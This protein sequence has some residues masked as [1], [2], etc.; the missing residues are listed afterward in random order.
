[1]AVTFFSQGGAEEVTGSRHFIQCEKTSVMLDCG[2]VQGHRGE[3]DRRNREWGGSFTPPDAVVLSHAHFDHCGLLPLL[4]QK[5][6][7]GNVYCT[8]PTAA[9]SNIVLLDSAKIQR[10]DHEFLQKEAHKNHTVF[11]GRPLYNENDIDK[12]TGHFV[13]IP[14]ETETNITPDSSVKFYNNAH[15]LGS[16]STLITIKEGLKK[17]RIFYTGDI[18]RAAHPFLPPSSYPPEAD[19]IIMEG[20]YGNRQHE[21]AEKSTQRLAEVIKE[22]A[23]GGGKTVIPA[24]AIDRTQHI[25]YTLHKLFT[26]GSIPDMPVFIDSP[27]AI[28]ATA[29]YNTYRLSYNDSYSV[30]KKRSEPFL[31]F[32]NLHYC[33]TTEESKK[34]NDYAGPCII[35]SASG[36]CE[37]GRILHHL[38]NT[39]ADSRNTILIIG[40]MAEDTLGR[41]IYNKA[42]VIKVFNRMLP[43]KARVEVFS[44]FSA[45]A[46]R[47]ELYRYIARLP[48]NKVKK[49][50]LVHGEKETL[51]AFKVYLETRGYP[52]VE[53]VKRGE[54]YRLL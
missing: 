27:M 3:A 5:A 48:K 46:D 16:A 9:L 37:S 39:A 24:F 35:I 26:N 8:M 19:Y 17:L 38:L 36:M 15:I 31:N 25:L 51:E 50:F 43:L 2:A 40:Y 34:I 11:K 45:H 4:A 30:N 52:D 47:S 22:T 13:T 12:L 44:A 42:P 21:D 41:H 28:A 33:A 29:V 49:I 14:L 20:T 32:K 23:D 53:V 6:F 7:A 1:M 54:T 10:S 18:G